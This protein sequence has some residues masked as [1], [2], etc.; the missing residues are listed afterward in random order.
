VK[1]D[2]QLPLALQVFSGYLKLSF[3]AIV[4]K[5]L[6]GRHLIIDFSIY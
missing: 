3:L 2:K 6:I 5:A 1:I 4:Q